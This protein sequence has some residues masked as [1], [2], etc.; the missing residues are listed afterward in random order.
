[1]WLNTPEL[2]A[3]LRPISADFWRNHSIAYWTSHVCMGSQSV[4]FGQP[5]ATQARSSSG[6]HSVVL[7]KRI[8]LGILP[9]ASHMRKVR[10]DTLRIAAASAAVSSSG[11]DTNGE[12]LAPPVF[13]SDVATISL[14]AG[15]VTS[16]IGNHY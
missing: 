5:A 8:G 16:I 12:L 2:Q 9:V 3:M 13:A 10:T 7:P 11:C 15:K 14:M 1:V 6:R 4:R